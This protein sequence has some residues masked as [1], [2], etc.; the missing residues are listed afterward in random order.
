[1][2]N[3][4]IMGKIQKCIIRAVSAEEELKNVYTLSKAFCHKTL[5]ERSAEFGR[6]LKS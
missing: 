4:V 5:E 1:M 6:K 3:Q 2:R